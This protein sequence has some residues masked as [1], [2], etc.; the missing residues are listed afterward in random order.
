MSLVRAALWNLSQPADIVMVHTVAEPAA[1]RKLALGMIARTLDYM[2]RKK[3]AIYVVQEKVYR[4]GTR[5]NVRY[6]SLADRG[7]EQSTL[8]LSV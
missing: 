6:Y 4:D 3:I 5:R 2:A 8:P 7:S 1:G